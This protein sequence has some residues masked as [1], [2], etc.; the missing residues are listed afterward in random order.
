MLK[1]CLED[2]EVLQLLFRAAED[3]ARAEMPDLAARAFMSATMTALQKKDGGS[4]HRHGHVFPKIG[5]E[6]VGETVWQVESVCSPFQFAHSTRAGTDC[7][8]HAIR[9]MTDTDH[10]TT[11][12]SIDGIGAYDHVLRSAM[13]AKLHGV[14][15]LRFV[16]FRASDLFK[17]HKICVGR[18]RWSEACHP[19]SRGR[20]TRD[21]LMPLLFCL[22]VHDALANVQMQLREGE[23]IFAFLD[24]VYVVTAPDH[25][26]SFQH[27]G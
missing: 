12:L 5:C 10:E 9:L 1:V 24:D 2:Q 16:A 11:V 14:P 6:D 25:A 15:G 13:M 4:W 17:T 18:R 3:A 21:P 8:S 27:V 19:P 20:R 22:A 23:H 26:R 7:V